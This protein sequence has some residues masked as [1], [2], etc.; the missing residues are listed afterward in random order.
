MPVIIKL[1]DLLAEDKPIY[2]RNRTKPR[3]RVDITFA[4]PGT[5]KVISVSV[6]RTRLPVCLSDEV[7]ASAIQSS[8]DFRRFLG[9]KI[10]ELV[11]PEVATKE[12][13]T[14]DAREELAALSES[15][16]ASSG[17]APAFG[18]GGPLQPN[19][20]NNAD[21]FEFE[22][23]QDD[24]INARVLQI[25]ASLDTEDMQVRQALQELRA[26]EDE[27]TME[28][29]SYIIARG[30]AGQVRKLAQKVLSSLTSKDVS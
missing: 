8:T 2:V 19:N 4:D 23:L 26:M 16:Y 24:M 3:G 30:R 15:Q 18:P 11:D 21:D 20:A 22:N 14:D 27:L 29:C 17:A 6:P 5:H 28:D 1:D 13:D 10:L 9:K 25:V 12:L 7:P